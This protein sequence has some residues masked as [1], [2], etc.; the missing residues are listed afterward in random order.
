MFSDSLTPVQEI[1]DEIN[2]AAT[3][4]A[5]NGLPVSH[6]NLSRIDELNTR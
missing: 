6:S 2:D 3:R 4:L 1:V 5:D